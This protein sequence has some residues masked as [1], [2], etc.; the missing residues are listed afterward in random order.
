MLY[1]QKK[2]KLENESR[3]VTEDQEDEGEEA[4]EDHEGNRIS[5]G[6]N[7]AKEANEKK[8]V[9]WQEDMLLA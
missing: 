8:K 7:A 5:F 1:L 9:S 3:L 4:F 2:D 6:G